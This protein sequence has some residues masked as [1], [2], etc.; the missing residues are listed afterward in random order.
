[1]QQAA[2]LIKQVT[3]DAAGFA[4][5][6]IFTITDGVTVTSKT[7][8]AVAILHG[9]YIDERGVACVQATSRIMVSE[10]A[11]VDAGFPTRDT[12]KKLSLK[13]CNVT[14]TDFATGVQATYVIREAIGNNFTGLTTCTLGT[15]GNVTPP[16]RIIIG[17]IVAS[18][19]ANPVTAT[20]GATQVLVNGDTIPS[21]Y[22][23]V[24]GNLVVPYM[25]GYSALTTFLVDNYLVQNIPYNK[26]TGTF[27]PTPITA[28]LPDVN[29][30]TFDATIPI[31]K[32]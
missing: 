16:G 26:A 21:E 22:V 28:F 19:I 8:N 10:P 31:W 1:M 25:V 2:N 13:D 17:W 7:C 11:L 27:T 12:N 20:T 29:Q 32:S 4:I 3:T 5:P 23:L 14:F 30:I 18:I 24:G 6:V 15:T 9:L